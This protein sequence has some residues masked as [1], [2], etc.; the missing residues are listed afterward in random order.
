[1][2]KLSKKRV[3]IVFINLSII[4]GL[5]LV[6]SLSFLIRKFLV[7]SRFFLIRQIKTNLDEV[8]QIPRREVKLPEYL[9]NK[10]N[11]FSLDINS[12]ASRLKEANPQY[13]D[14]IIQRKFP[15]SLYIEFVRRI[16]L[17]QVNIA[18]KFWIVDEDSV[19]ISGLGNE[20]FPDKIAVYTTLPKGL[21]ISVGKQIPFSYSRNVVSLNL[22]FYLFLIFNFSPYSQ[23]LMKLRNDFCLNTVVFANLLKILQLLAQ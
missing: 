6:F 13:K 1:M 22:A 3:R 8:P 15:D 12:L 17:F 18:D 23:L 19:V 9:I 5:I 20:P 2:K 10:Q 4:G 11:L 21:S 16:G 14:V 7:E